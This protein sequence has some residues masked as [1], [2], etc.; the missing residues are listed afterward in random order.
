[1]RGKLLALGLLICAVVAGG[2]MYYLQI[3]GYYREVAATGPEDVVIVA[4]AS[5]APEPIAHSGFRAIDAESSPI[6]YRACFTTTVSPDALAE[7]HWQIKA[8]DPRN[9]P[10]WFDCF[11]A[12]A[13]A[14][15]IADGSARVFM[16]QKNVHYGV[17]R[18]VVITDDGHGFAWNELNDCGAKAYDGTVVGEEC[19]E[20]EHDPGS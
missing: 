18:I 2:A 17:D 13:I 8:A 5:N 9:A 1:M 4:L 15:Q 10:G 7:T 6:R 16:G 11:D 12:A 20:P 3:Y 19:P 14:G